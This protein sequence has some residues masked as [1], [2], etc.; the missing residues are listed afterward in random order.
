M[1]SLCSDELLFTPAMQAIS[2]SR[3]QM[4]DRGMRKAVEAVRGQASAPFPQQPASHAQTSSF[5]SRGP[6]SMPSTSGRPMHPSGPP[7]DRMPASHH[8]NRQSTFARPS[9]QPASDAS[10][11]TAQGVPAWMQKAKQAGDPPNSLCVFRLIFLYTKTSHGL[12]G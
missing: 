7:P 9:Q 12:S 2:L 6:S 4:A 5:N 8:P 10:R 11:Q 3:K 1:Y